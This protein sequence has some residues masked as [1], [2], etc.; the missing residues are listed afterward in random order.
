MLRRADVTIRPS[1]L[2]QCIGF[3]IGSTF[4]AIG[5]APGLAEKLGT[6]NA[7]VSFFIGSWFFTTA[8]FMQL[9]L[10]GKMRNESG[11]LRAVWLTASTQFFGTLLFNL[12]TGMAL[13]AKTRTANIDFVWA[14]NA[15]GSAAFLISGAFALLVLVRS[16]NFFGPVNVDW[17]SAWVNMLGCIAFGL[18]AVGA[19]IL[20][21]GSTLNGQL[22]T[23]GTFIGAICFFVAS[24]VALPTA[25]RQRRQ[26]GSGGASA[27]NAAEAG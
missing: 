21:S 19:V 18:S 27:E 3:M 17:S 24:M 5:S 23:W 11:A 1:L 22:A 9:Q 26:R 16:G 8:A 4:F 20:T 14:P 13:E 25:M 2:M 6:H 7:N 10:S 12:S 15:E